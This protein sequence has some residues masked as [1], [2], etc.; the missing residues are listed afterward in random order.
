M[1]P[2]K[3]DPFAL[4]LI[5]GMICI[6]IVLSIQKLTDKGDLKCVQEITVFTY[7]NKL[8]II[9][10]KNGDRLTCVEFK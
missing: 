5:V 1:H 9:V 10:D 8:Y 6:T 7:N 3:L 4:I 2:E